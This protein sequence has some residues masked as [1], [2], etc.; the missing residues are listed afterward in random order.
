MSGFTVLTCKQS[1]KISKSYHV[2]EG[3]NYHLLILISIGYCT[4]QFKEQEAEFIMN[5]ELEIKQFQKQISSISNRLDIDWTK[6][7][8]I[9]LPVKFN[10]TD[11][12]A[13]CYLDLHFEK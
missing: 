9:F 8:Q 7:Q 10:S 12:I 11:W 3:D 4:G 1:D 5:P 6:K 13:L 2:K